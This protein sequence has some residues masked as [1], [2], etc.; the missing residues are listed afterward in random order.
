MTRDEIKKLIA[1][2]NTET[3]K[4]FAKHNGALQVWKSW[5]DTMLQ[6]NREVNPKFMDLPIPE[7][8]MELDAQIAFDVISDF[9]FWASSHP[10]KGED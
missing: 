5:R 4:Q 10:H 6:Q 1:N 7:R 9:I 8:D 3:I 2:S